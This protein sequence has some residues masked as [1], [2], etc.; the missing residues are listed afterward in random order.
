MAA[1]LREWYLFPE[2]LPATLDAAAYATVSDYVD[3]LTTEA[4]AQ[5][6]DRY[7]TY[8]TSIKS[9]DAYY[10]TGQTAGFGI[11]I[12][13]DLVER[14]V[15][16]VDV[17]DGSSAEGRHIKRGAEIF[18]VG[19]EGGVLRSVDSILAEGGEEALAAAFGPATPGLRRA[20]RMRTDPAH[21]G[22]STTTIDKADF[23][24]APVSPRYGMK[25]IEHG[26]EQIAYLNL[27]TFINP[28]TPVLKAA[29]S[30]FQRQGVDKIIIDLRYNGGG[31]LNVANALGDLLGGN[32]QPGDVFSYSNFRP[33][34]SGN[35]ITRRFERQVESFSP[36]KI[37]FIVTG[38]SA[39]ASEMLINSMA[40][41][42]RENSAIIG[43]NT[44]GKPVGQIA[45]DRGICD[46]RLRLVAFAVQNADRQG[47]YFDGLA[48]RTGASCSAQDDLSREMGDPTETSTR[49]ALDFLQGRSCVPIAQKSARAQ[50]ATA[51]RS[52]VQP[53]SPTIAQRDAPGTF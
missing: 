39:S 13:T 22:I 9:E 36:V 5:G 31:L 28:A 7:F 37:A 41:W 50:S 35:D 26:G 2:T 14:R 34:K 29:F 30:N 19:P 38:E 47:D 20:F 25:L 23:A 15:F 44:Y 45:L 49:A 11:R 46:D 6:R 21:T 51:S 43:S 1:Q 8:L 33:S 53:G 12:Q 24:I 48:G 17:Y 42:L 10:D 27:R 18:A 4:R 32:R 40:P 52:L 3:A 16:V